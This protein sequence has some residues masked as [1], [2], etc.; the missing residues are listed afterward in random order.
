M[1]NAKRLLATLYTDQATMLWAADQYE[2]AVN[3]LEKAIDIYTELGDTYEAITTR[4]NLGIVFW[5]M[6][7]LD[8]AEAAIRDSLQLAETFNARWRMMNEV[9]N[10]CAISFSGSGQKVSDE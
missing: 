4:G 2:T 6:A 5:S 8:E 9:G 10:L 7:R 1:F 3:S